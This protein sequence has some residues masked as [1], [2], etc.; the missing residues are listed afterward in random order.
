MKRWQTAVAVLIG[1]VV[2]VGLGYVLHVDMQSEVPNTTLW[3]G[4]LTAIGVVLTAVVTQVS[5]KRREIEARHF[6]QKREAYQGMVDVWTSLIVANMSAIG[7]TGK[8]DEQEIARQLVDLKR[9]AMFWGDRDVVRWWI[10]MNEDIEDW[11]QSPVDMMFQVDRLFRLMR[12][13][14][15]KDNSGIRQGDLLGLYLTGGRKALLDA[16]KASSAG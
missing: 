4:V 14:L 2:A 9:Q 13:E 12:Q 16:R 15:G 1:A 6:E 10:E 5:T 8:I 7:G 3:V 11:A